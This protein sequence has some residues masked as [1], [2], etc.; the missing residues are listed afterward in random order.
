M[1]KIFA[2]LL[3]AVMTSSPLVGLLFIL[4]ACSSNSGHQSIRLN[5]ENLWTDSSMTDDL[6]MGLPYAM[7]VKDGNLIILDVKNN[8]F[9]LQYDVRKCSPVG[10]YGKRGMGPDDLMMPMSL[11]LLDGRFY[12]YD[13]TSS[14]L[15]TIEMPSGGGLQFHQQGRLSSADWHDAVIPLR[16]GMYAA[17]GSYE[18]GMLKLLDK[19]GKC[20]DTTADY[21][22]SENDRNV[23]NINR[24][25]AYQ[26]RLSYNGQDRLVYVTSQAKECF[27]YRIAGNKMIQ[28]VTQIDSYPDYVDSSKGEN[29]S[30]TFSRDNPYGYTDVFAGK[31]GFYAAYCGVSMAD[32]NPSCYGRSTLLY[33]YNYKGEVEKSYELDVPI[34]IFTVDEENSVIYAIC[35]NPQPE[36]VRFRY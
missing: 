21:P 23:P 34:S 1:R 13:M 35:F 2:A 19:D 27:V 36:L 28:E 29:Y 32:D 25:M 31:K 18:S 5:H 8:K 17:K 3:C 11:S 33:R 9:F 26:G 22:F 14:R 10:I 12:T 20:L 15:Y 6:Y 4:G 30:A 16:D 24:S 7:A